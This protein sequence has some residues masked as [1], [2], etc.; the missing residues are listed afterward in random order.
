MIL[1]AHLFQTVIDFLSFQLDK[2]SLNRSCFALQSSCRCSV[3]QF[4]VEVLL[5]KCPPMFSI[6]TYFCPALI[7]HQK[8]AF[9]TLSALKLL[10]EGKEALKGLK[11]RADGTRARTALDR[12]DGRGEK[13]NSM[14]AE[15]KRLR[16]VCQ[17][18]KIC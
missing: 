11:P 17:A 13:A 1:N 12:Q 3:G 2:C 9:H 5:L 15:V 8:T 4:K 14:E 16:K 18:L 6:C 7:R 10:V